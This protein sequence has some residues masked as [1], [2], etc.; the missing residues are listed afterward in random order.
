MNRQETPDTAAIHDPPVPRQE[1][2]KPVAPTI[3]TSHLWSVRVTL[4]QLADIAEIVGNLIVVITLIYLAIQIRQGTDVIRS[5]SR[6]AQVTTDQNGVYLFVHYPEL[7]NY[8]AQQQSPTFEEK[9]KL[10]F[11]IIAQMRAR[12]HEWL[13]FR[14]GALDEETWLSYRDVIYFLLGTKRSRALWQLCSPYFNKE[15]VAE[16]ARM[17]QGFPETD[18][19][20]R[21]DAVE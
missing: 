16:V 7:S 13:Q 12:E 9:T 1:E 2:A 18:F 17:M 19:W 21:L 20:Q 6:Q 10:I 15:F 3:T 5:D 8:F 4:D 11:W 14:S